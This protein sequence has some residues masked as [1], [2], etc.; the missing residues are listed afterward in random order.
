MTRFTKAALAALLIAGV[1]TSCKK[2]L[3]TDTQG[4]LPAKD[5]Q[6]LVITSPNSPLTVLGNFGNPTVVPYTGFAP[7][8][9][10]LLNGTQSGTASGQVVFNGIS[11]A[12]VQPRPGYELRFLSTTIPFD[13][14]R[15]SHF[16]AANIS[17]S[18][19]Q[20]TPNNG[21]PP[22]GW[23]NYV[24]PGGVSIIPNF[25]I[26]VRSTTGGMSYALKFTNVVGTGTATNN[27]ADYTIQYGFIT[28]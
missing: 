5:E 28:P 22:N 1:A 19:G 21:T 6:A 7:V 10:N 2:G 20:N 16:P 13:S 25:Y 11:N 26:L 18:I 4:T 24:P 14:L 17:T 23:F 15:I 8:Y 12:A 3:D 27:K 9:V